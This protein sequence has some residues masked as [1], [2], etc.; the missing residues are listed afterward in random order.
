MSGASGIERHHDFCSGTYGCND[1]LVFCG[2]MMELK[3]A[4]QRDTW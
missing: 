4:A 1:N 2:D 3:G